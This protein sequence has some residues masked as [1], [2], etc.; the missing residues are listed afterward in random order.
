[1]EAIGKKIRALRGQ[2]NLSDEEFAE[3]IGIA[4]SA[5]WAYEGGKKLITVPHLT[6]I[7][8]FFGVSTDFLLNRST[9]KVKLDLQNKKGLS[10][11][12]FVIDNRP[13]NEDEIADVAAYIRTRRRMGND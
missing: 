10:G 7:A 4:K 1:M 2:Q 8:D 6:K 5:V 9:S 12:I 13:M 11:Y 3:K